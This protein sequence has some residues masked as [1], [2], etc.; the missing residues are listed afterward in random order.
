MTLLSDTIIKIWLENNTPNYNTWLEK[1][2]WSLSEAVF[3]LLGYDPITSLSEDKFSEGS[4]F[5]LRAHTLSLELTP[6]NPID[7]NLF[8][9]L[10][11]LYNRIERHIFAKELQAREKNGEFWIEPGNLLPFLIEIDFKIPP[12]LKNTLSLENDSIA[13]RLLNSSKDIIPTSSS[14]T[15]FTKS[16]VNKRVASTHSGQLPDDFH[17]IEFYY[18]PRWESLWL[19][20]HLSQERALPFFL[21][22]LKDDNYPDRL[23]RFIMQNP[24]GAIIDTSKF[25]PPAH[26]L[27]ELMIKKVLRKV[28]LNDNKTSETQNS[29]K[30]NLI[31]TKDFPVD[32][33]T[34]DILRYLRT[35][36]RKETY[37]RPSFPKADYKSLY[38]NCSIIG[39]V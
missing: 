19:I 22:K 30:G 20:L 25:Q 23:A 29:W 18:H 15:T 34:K 13:Q 27:G 1:P 9:E 3:L 17:A 31:Y 11:N 14:D 32:I 5:F 38:P 24:D 8:L 37:K 33:S 39:S 26:T 35:I 4:S 7:I 21:K 2:S 12:E 10:L 36:N 16:S 28:F 6:N